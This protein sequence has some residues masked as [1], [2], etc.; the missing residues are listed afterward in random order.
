M[1]PGF[2]VQGADD[3]VWVHVSL[4]GVSFGPPLSTEDV[5]TVGTWLGPRFW[6]HDK[7]STKTAEEAA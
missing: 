2:S 1:L 5:A 4:S 6:I 3:F 7:Y